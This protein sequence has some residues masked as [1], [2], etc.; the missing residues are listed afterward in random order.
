MK[1]NKLH[2]KKGIIKVIPKTKSKDFK[3]FFMDEMRYGLISN[4]CRSWSK[5]GKRTVIEN[6]QGFQ[7]VIVIVIL[8]LLMETH[9]I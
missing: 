6:Q 3:L 9:F 2:L 7:V 8:T 1:R 5:V 4:V